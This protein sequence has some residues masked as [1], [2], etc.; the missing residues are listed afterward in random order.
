LDQVKES[1]P[2]RFNYR[3]SWVNDWS[4]HLNP[5][6]STRA[7]D[8]GFPWTRPDCDQLAN[9]DADDKYRCQRFFFSDPL[10]E[11]LTHIFVRKD[12][13]IKTGADE[14]IAGKSLCRPSGYE[15][16]EL[17]QDGRNWVKDGKIVLIRPQSVDECF[18]LLD[19]GTVEAVAVNDMVGLAAAESTGVASK[20]RMIDRPLAIRTLH[21]VVSKGH[22]NARTVLYYVNSAL[23][24]LKESGAFDRIVGEHL[25]S[26]WDPGSTT[27]PAP[28][29]TSSTTSSTTQT[30][31]KEKS[32]ASTA[33]TGKDGQSKGAS[34]EASKADKTKK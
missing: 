29:S 9:L 15:I 20:V 31:A 1:A 17:D 12:S 14:E 4:A 24:K 11:D 18:R 7:F 26:F 33:S 28:D 19:G 13:P 25:R 2:D 32:P 34:A 30:D 8:A 22:P 5:L 6:L 23:A 16:Y 3:I 27:R 21:V 10:F